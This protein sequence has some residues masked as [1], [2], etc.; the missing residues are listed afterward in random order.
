MSYDITLEY[1]P[2][3]LRDMSDEDLGTLLNQAQQSFFELRVK[4][5]SERVKPHQFGKVKRDI[6]RIKTILAEL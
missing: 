2:E 4:D 3:F 1:T 5:A 6:A